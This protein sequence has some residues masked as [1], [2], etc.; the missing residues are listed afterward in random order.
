[1][2]MVGYFSSLLDSGVDLD[3]YSMVLGLLNILLN[4]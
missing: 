3:M 4:Q 2:A 1:M